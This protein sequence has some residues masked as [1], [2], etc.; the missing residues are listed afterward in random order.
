M[1]KILSFLLLINIISTPVYSV[2]FDSSIDGEIRKNYKIEESELPPLPEE[3][4]SAPIEIKTPQ[5][6][7]TGKTYN[8][9]SGT[10]ISVQSTRAITDRTPMGTKV[11][12]AATNAITTK[13]GAII[14]TGTILKGTITDSHPPQLSGNGGLIELKI[15][16]IY[17]NGI[18]SQI[19][20][21]VSL[22]NSKKIFLGNIKGKRSYWKN[23]SK[24][25]KP[26]RAT[27]NAAQKC[28]KALAPIPVIN[29]LSIVPLTGGIA[30]YTVNL[31][32]SPVVAIFTKG[33]SLS[34]PKGTLFQIKITEDSLING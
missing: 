23:F 4:A 8:L 31:A 18:M 7:P 32:L 2:E 6:N 21:K 29:I 3:T 19:N 24:V 5:Y 14:P 16:E 13:E 26:G 30:V 27:Y 10:K 11:S 28:A 33:K 9:K 25:M 17:Y 22:A 34:L 1:K 15:D 12:F 20:S